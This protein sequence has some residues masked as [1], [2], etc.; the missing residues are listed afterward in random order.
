MLGLSENAAVIAAARNC[1][2]RGEGSATGTVTM[3]DRRGQVTGEWSGDGFDGDLSPGGDVLVTTH[4]TIGEDGDEHLFTY[5]TGTGKTMRKLKLRL[6][7]E[8]SDARGH[9][10]LDAD[11]YIV[12]AEPPEPGGSFG[13]YQVNVRTGKSQWIRDLGLDLGDRISLG[14]VR[15]GS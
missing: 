3:L 8:P 15:I 13:Y 6:L 10:W 4:A 2:E 7:S 11:E 9:G 12:E 5:D 14:D 1:P